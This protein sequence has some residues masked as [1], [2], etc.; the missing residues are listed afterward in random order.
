MSRARSTQRLPAAASRWISFRCRR[1][2]GVAALASLVAMAPVALGCGYEDPN[3]AAVQ[4]GVL[5][6]AYP[7][8]L[9]VLGALTQARLNGVIAPPADA[10]AG[11]DPFGA[12]FS[13]TARM[14]QQFGDALGVEPPASDDLAFSLVLIEPMLWTRF[15]VRDEGVATSV[16]VNGPAVGDLVVIATE[17]VLREIVGRRLT[18]ERAEELGLIRIYGDPARTAQLRAIFAVQDKAMNVVAPS[19]TYRPVSGI[20]DR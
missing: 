10:P 8:A 14:L 7:N 11:K 4:R 18:P 20:R 1:A 19:L 17:A 5:N 6:F 15:A 9:H 12:R 2:I 16:H 13:K 3:S